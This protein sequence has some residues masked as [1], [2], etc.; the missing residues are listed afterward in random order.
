MSHAPELRAD[1]VAHHLL[2]LDPEA[3]ACDDPGV[4][5][6]FLTHL[7]NVRRETT[8][9]LLPDGESSATLPQ[10]DYRIEPGGTRIVRHPSGR[11]IPGWPRD[12]E[13]CTEAAA[14]Q[15]LAEALK[16]ARGGLFVV[17]G[18][19][20]ADVLDVADH[21]IAVA[22]DDARDDAVSLGRGETARL[23][24]VLEDLQLFLRTARRISDLC[25][26][27]FERAIGSLRRNIVEMGFTAA[28]LGDNRLRE[29]DANYAAV[30]SRDGIITG[31]WTLCLHDEAMRH[32]FRATLEALAGHQTP[33]GQIPA[34]VRIDGSGAEYSGLGGIAS[35]DAVLWF[36]IG[37]SRYAFSL[38]DVEFARSMLPSARRAMT[39]LAAHDSNNDGLIEIPEASDWMDLFPRSYNVL[40]DEV[41]WYQ[42]CCDHAALLEALGEDASDWR[43]WSERVKER[44]HEV[45]WPTG[46]HLEELTHS[47]DRLH[48]A[49]ESGGPFL[50]CSVTP[51]DHSWRCD[52][53]AN[54]LAALTGLLDEDQSE[55]LFEFLWGVGVN[56]PF[57]VAC[58]YPAVQSGAEDWKDYFVVNFLN[59]PHHYHN[60]GVW[61]FIGGLWVRFL[62]HV[63]RTELAHRELGA[64]AAAC[65]SGL[66]GEWEFNE[67]LHGITGR[68]MGKLHQAWSAASYVKAYMTLTKQTIP[69]DFNALDPCTLG[70]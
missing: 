60:G 66:R 6:V 3:L 10:G 58:L 7:A 18:P 1:A 36:V 34:N 28:S 16:L 39:W 30:W 31:L 48:S 69:A 17:A 14:V 32:A 21:A 46:L 57:P 11:A 20:H 49:G 12:G 68:P 56:S 19:K 27:A 22:V 47:A 29:H 5:S 38:R 62:H 41:L 40:Y 23:T 33:T 65:R 25:D 54:L 2:V 8:I 44:I 24:R 15:H 63:G 45:F 55:Q 50:L 53:Y 37:V 35:I 42:A 61:P 70:G 59:L 52:V 26:E 9:A 4:L 13:P 64:L 43:S 51:F 67:W